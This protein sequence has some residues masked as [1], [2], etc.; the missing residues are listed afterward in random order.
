MLLVV[1]AVELAQTGATIWHFGA[2]PA[3]PQYDYGFGAV[4]LLGWLA[5]FGSRS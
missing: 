3:S 2:H 1:S 4:V 5:Y